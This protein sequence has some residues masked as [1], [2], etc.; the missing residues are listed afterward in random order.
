MKQR[1]TTLS[2]IPTHGLVQQLLRTP[3]VSKLSIA[4]QPL[5]VKGH[6]NKHSRLTVSIYS[7]SLSQETGVRRHH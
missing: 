2:N 4:E 6:A 5:E 7:I 3:T 1:N